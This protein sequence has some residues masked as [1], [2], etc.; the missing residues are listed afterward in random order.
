M[1]CCPP[2]E[3]TNVMGLAP[4]YYL[5]QVG[6]TLSQ[7]A[8]LLGPIADVVPSATYTYLVEESVGIH[9][10][11]DFG[12][13]M[14][15]NV[16]F[17]SL[18]GVLSLVVQGDQIIASTTSNYITIDISVVEICR[19]TNIEELDISAD[20]RGQYPQGFSGFFE[21]VEPDSGLVAGWVSKL[22]AEPKC[23]R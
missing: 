23:K 16:R 22:L 3:V 21:C 18:P 15:E 4:V 20:G 19:I 14:P 7:S 17:L 8:R 11:A 6:D 10:I 1:S 13:L 2:E 9:V 5:P 12:E